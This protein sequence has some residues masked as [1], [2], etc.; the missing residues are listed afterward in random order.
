LGALIKG[1]YEVWVRADP[2]ARGRIDTS[3]SGFV[4]ELKSV[5]GKVLK[6]KKKSTKEQKKSA[7]KN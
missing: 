3:S 2:W 7:K 1:L 4:Y 6:R 5:N